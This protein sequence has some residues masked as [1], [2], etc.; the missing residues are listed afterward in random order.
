M[1]YAVANLAFRG[2]AVCLGW[3]GETHSHEHP[4]S[5]GTIMSKSVEGGDEDHVLPIQRWLST[6]VVPTIASTIALVQH[7]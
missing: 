5:G 3:R 6:Y 7:R 2:I 1:M 4:P